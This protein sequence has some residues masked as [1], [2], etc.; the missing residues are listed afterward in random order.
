M[1]DNSPDAFDHDWGPF[2]DGDDLES[3]PPLFH[4]EIEGEDNKNDINGFTDLGE[5]MVESFSSEVEFKRGSIAQRRAAKLGFDDSRIHVAQFKSNPPFS[6]LSSCSP[7]FTIPSG[8]SPAALLESPVMLPNSQISPTT[9]TFPQASFN[10]DP[11]TVESVDISGADDD[12]GK[13]ITSA[14]ATTTDT[15]A[16]FFM[17]PAARDLTRQIASAS[18]AENKNQEI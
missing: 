10:H 17:C 18:S 8:I 6:S 14:A 5:S 9:G 13:G 2:V 1:Q 7:F 3:K 16:K 11:L 4:F 12:K 15:S